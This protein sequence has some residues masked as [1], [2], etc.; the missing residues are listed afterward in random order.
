MS[1]HA[2]ITYSACAQQVAEAFIAHPVEGS[3][4]SC[5][6]DLVPQ[7]VLPPVDVAPNG[8][9]ATPAAAASTYRVVG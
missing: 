6:A 7:W 8:D 4:T 5:F 3:D 9:H 2:V 1:G